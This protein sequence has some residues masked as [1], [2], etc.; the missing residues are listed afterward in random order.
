[1]VQTDFTISREEKRNVE[2][3]KLNGEEMGRENKAALRGGKPAVHGGRE[4]LCV[5]GALLPFGS[6]FFFRYVL[7]TGAAVP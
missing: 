6:R 5:I 7:A 1:M 4:P 3:Q 2:G